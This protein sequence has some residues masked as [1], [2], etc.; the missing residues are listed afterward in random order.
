MTQ[1][2]IMDYRP[3]YQHM[4]VIK[5]IILIQIQCCVLKLCKMRTIDMMIYSWTSVAST[6]SYGTTQTNSKTSSMTIK[7]KARLGSFH[8]T[9]LESSWNSMCETRRQVESLPRRIMPRTELPRSEL[10]SKA[11]SRLVGRWR[12]IWRASSKWNR[13]W[14]AS[15]SYNSGRRIGRWPMRRCSRIITRILRVKIRITWN[16]DE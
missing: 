6:Y 1:I 7:I 15:W 10:R 12:W 11:W 2:L 9:T 13:I 4:S 5:I 3:W 16:E 14:R 8:P